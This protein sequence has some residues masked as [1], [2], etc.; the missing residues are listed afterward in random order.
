M[1]G[2]IFKLMKEKIGI[3]PKKLCTLIKVIKNA[4]FLIFLHPSCTDIIVVKQIGGQ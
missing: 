3:T 1:S 4:T 2:V